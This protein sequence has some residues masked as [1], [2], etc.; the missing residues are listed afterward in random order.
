MRY[1]IVA[2]LGYRVR[3]REKPEGHYQVAVALF[4]AATAFL[5]LITGTERRKQGSWRRPGI[6]PQSDELQITRSR[7][8]TDRAR[9]RHGPM[10]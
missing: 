9:S 4:A 3:H 6:A 5:L 10:Q 8:K 7:V 2:V 1:G